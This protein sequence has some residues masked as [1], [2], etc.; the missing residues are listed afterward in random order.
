MDIQQRIEY[1]E[2]YDALVA[3]FCATLDDDIDCQ[4]VYMCDEGLS[5]T[6]MARRLG[7]RTHSAVTK[8][9]QKIYEKCCAFLE[10]QPKD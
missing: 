7:F 1:D 3:A 9:I 8:R 4:I 6:E 2:Q 5:Q 10:A